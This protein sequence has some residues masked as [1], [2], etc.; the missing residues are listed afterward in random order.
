[1][2]SFAGMAQVL[3]PEADTAAMATNS[4]KVEAAVSAFWECGWGGVGFLQLA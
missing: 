4:V 3:V 2:Q 1:M